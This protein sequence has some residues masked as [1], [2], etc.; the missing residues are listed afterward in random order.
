MSPF[1]LT[2]YN[3]NVSFIKEL[4]LKETIGVSEYYNALVYVLSKYLHFIAT[5]VSISIKIENSMEILLEELF[6]R[7]IH[8]E[9]YHDRKLHLDNQSCQILGI[10]QS[11]KT[12]LVKNYLSGLKKSTYLYIDCSDERFSAKDLNSH[13]R[14]FCYAKKIETLAL[15]NYTPDIDIPNVTQLILIPQKEVEF[16]KTVWVMPLD[17]EEFLAYEHKFDSTALNHYLQLGGLPIM[18]RIPQEERVLFMQQK[19]RLALSETEF[20]ILKLI[21]RFNA[22]QLSPYTI[23]ERL[24]QVR[25]ISK[26]KTYT[27]Y[28]SLL[29]KRYFFELPKYNHPKAIKRLY[30]GDIFLKNALSLDKHFA[31]LFENLLFLELFKREETLYYAEGIDFYLPNKQEVV[32]AK[33]FAEERV[34]FKKLESLE[35]FLISNNIQ[36]VTAVTMS[37]EATI[38]HP[39]SKVEM[40]PFDIWALGE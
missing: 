12:K 13:L 27:A 32:F 31:R 20:D 21:A 36:K 11:G 14:S 28:K 9:R 37:K 17:Y 15:D 39:F 7:D 1:K 30:L 10:T 4:L 33:P 5:I 26:D 23:Y 35:A 34:L 8:L 2:Y 19:L 16:L 25:K 3:C 22:M 38:S 6:L 18:H 40:I 24:K 29:K